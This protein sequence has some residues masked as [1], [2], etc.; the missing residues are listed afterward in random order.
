LRNRLEEGVE[1]HGSCPET[2]C[3]LAQQ[4]VRHGYVRRARLC[5]EAGLQRHPGHRLIARELGRI[6]QAQGMWETAL[7]YYEQSQH[8]GLS[9]LALETLGRR[10]EAYLAWVRYQAERQVELPELNGFAPCGV[11]LHNY[12]LRYGSLLLHYELASWRHSAELGWH[13]LPTERELA[14]LIAEFLTL[15]QV[16]GWPITA[17]VAAAIDANWV[18]EVIATKLGVR[19][20]SWDEL[21]PEDFVLCFALTSDSLE[22]KQIPN[23]ITFGLSGHHLEPS[24]D[25]APDIV[26]NSKSRPILWSRVAQCPE[27]GRLVAEH[28]RRPHLEHCCDRHK[29]LR[30]LLQPL[31][32]WKERA[33]ALP[34]PSEDE[35]CQ[36]LGRGD[37]GALEWI[38]SD[39]ASEG[40]RMAAREVLELADPDTAERLVEIVLSDPKADWRSVWDEFPQ[41]RTRIFFRDAG[42]S[43]ADLRDVIRLALVSGDTELRKSGMNWAY[44]SELLACAATL[45]GL[46]MEKYEEARV[47][48]QHQSP[49]VLRAKLNSLCDATTLK[50]LINHL[51][52]RLNSCWA[53]EI[54][55]LLQHSESW[56]R[57][58][59]G[60]LLA[61]WGEASLQELVELAES[62]YGS[63]ALDKLT[64]IDP[65][66]AK[67]TALSLLDTN[68][69]AALECLL[70]LRCRDGLQRCRE[71]VRLSLRVYGSVKYLDAI[72][73]PDEEMLETALV[74]SR[75]DAAQALIRRGYSQYWEVFRAGLKGEFDYEYTSELL[76]WGSLEALELLLEVKGEVDVLNEID[77]YENRFRGV[78]EMIPVAR[79]RLAARQ[80]LAK[81]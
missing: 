58:S 40:I 36:R 67:A 55:T 1:L 20:C 5:L 21:W 14:G 8:H 53:P 30:P 60:R 37:W 64:E 80:L 34:K 4:Y 70:Q 38:E 79:E 65:G 6:A 81:T 33:A 12:D 78:G 29:H 75:T 73:E 3:S 63:L 41:L 28:P 57:A 50:A 45:A 39:Q 56:V 32:G 25:A 47:W 35:L 77:F 66:L 52:R 76:E 74:R 18:T 51:E 62:C 10:R 44:S 31:P 26:G 61:K 54:R 46:E 22:R 68:P 72:G 19:C 13:C 49:E 71:I 59:A 9:A 24:M 11:L 27:L 42:W 23:G 69:Q 15:Q 16:F 2:V 48:F 17:V 7:G 43:D